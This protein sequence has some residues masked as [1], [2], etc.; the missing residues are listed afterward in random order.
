MMQDYLTYSI[1]RILYIFKVLNPQILILNKNLYFWGIFEYYKR[2][3]QF[4]KT[5]RI[6]FFFITIQY[7]SKSSLGNEYY[8]NVIY[9]GSY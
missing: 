4:F 2:D 5:K 8:A 7:N 1:L 6:H 9:N 3:L